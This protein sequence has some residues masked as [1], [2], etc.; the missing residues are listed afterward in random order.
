[1][2]FYP[3]SRH[4]IRSLISNLYPNVVAEEQ[5]SPITSE[6]LLPHLLYMCD[7]METWDTSS[8]KRAVKAGRWI[9]W[10]FRSMEELNLW[11]NNT[12]RQYARFDVFD[13]RVLPH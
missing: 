3:T 7:E 1:L 6:K 5:D 11:D 2:S 12:S 9:G 10:M 13:G 4:A 8:V